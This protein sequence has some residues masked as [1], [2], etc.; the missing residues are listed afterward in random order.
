MLTEQVV[1]A[2]LTLPVVQG[3]ARGGTSASFGLQGRSKDGPDF[4][5]HAIEVSLSGG[6]AVQQPPRNPSPPPP[7]VE[8]SSRLRSS[9]KLF[10]DVAI[11]DVDALS[12]DQ[13]SQLDSELRAYIASLFRSGGPVVHAADIV[14]ES[15]RAGSV[16]VEFS[17]LHITLDQLQTG[18][19]RSVT[20][21][22]NVNFVVCSGECI[23]G[24]AVVDESGASRPPV[25]INEPPSDDS[26]STTT[27]AT[28]PPALS[29]PSTATPARSAPESAHVNATAAPS[30]GFERAI[31]GHLLHPQFLSL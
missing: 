5:I 30:S 10:L 2:Q 20:S 25:Y 17:V 1:L 12:T 11:E 24:Y 7:A 28:P 19:Q 9:G 15:I 21:L 8:P 3:A 27:V 18:L 6:A 14:I 31:V 16:A 29:G 22:H 13:A 4:E 26:G 23:L